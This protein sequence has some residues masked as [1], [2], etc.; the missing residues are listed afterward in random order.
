[1]K[2]EHC[3]AASSFEEQKPRETNAI[4]HPPVTQWLCRQTQV[5]S[6]A[7]AWRF[8]RKHRGLV[9]EINQT[10]LPQGLDWGK[11]KLFHL[12]AR[13][14]AKAESNKSHQ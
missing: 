8:Y 2:D 14:F 6:T 1:L 3:Y 11:A 7:N 13:H 5:E 12:E 4:T 9:R 10:F